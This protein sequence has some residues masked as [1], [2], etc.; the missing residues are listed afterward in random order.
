MK[1]LRG[2]AFFLACTAYATEP[3]DFLDQL[4]T[5]LSIAAFH[6]NLRLRLSGTIDLEG[7]H[8][9]QPAPGLIDSRLDTL[10]NTRLTLFLDAHV[11]SHISVSA[12]AGLG[13]GF[14]PTGHGAQMR[15]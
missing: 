15:A 6:D 12:H 8:L 13:R 5:A 11:G 2:L 1:V 9:Q 7:Y 4:D 10:F 14:A 3:D